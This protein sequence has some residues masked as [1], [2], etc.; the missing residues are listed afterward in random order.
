MTPIFQDLKYAIR[1][2]SKSPG[3]SAIAV[4]TL[5][6]GIGANAAIF[7][8]VDRVLLRLL[9]VRNPNELVLLRS[10]GPSSGHT[11][12]DGDETT[13][14][15]YPMYR[16]LRDRSA[17]VFSGLVGELP[18][19]V[20]LAA[21]GRTERAAGELVTGNYFSVLGVAPAAGRTL[22]VPDDAAPGGSPGGGPLPRILD[23]TFRRRPRR[24]RAEHRRE[25][26]AAS[27]RRR[28][29]RRLQ[30]DPA[31]SQCGSLRADDDEGA[32][33]AVLGR[34]RRSEGLLGPDRR[35]SQAGPV[36]EARRG[37]AVARL[38]S[39]SPRPGAPHEILARGSC[40]VREPEADPRPR[41]PR[42]DDAAQRSRHAASLAHGDGR[43]RSA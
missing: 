9:P 14:F 4:L 13:S 10:P 28:L 16:D 18:F 25:R 37:G 23:A 34:P 33:D 8:L 6:L 40:E 20:S 27:R 29:A 12:S 30:R 3:F 7:A 41:G 36:R 39:A 2:I 21:R 42:P 24:R 35:P 19:D 5:A 15:S 38:P 31:G 32:D 43:A 11:W 22:A 17:H 26:L 1:T